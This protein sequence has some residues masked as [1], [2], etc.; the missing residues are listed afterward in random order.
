MNK[1]KQLLENVI[2]YL[3]GQEWS[4]QK[5]KRKTFDQIFQID[6]VPLT[7]FYKRLLLTY[8]LPHKFEIIKLLR[9]A[10]KKEKITFWEGKKYLGWSYLYRYLL[11]INEKMKILAAKKVKPD[12]KEKILFLIP[13]NHFDQ[14]KKFY[15]RVNPIMEK[16]KKEGKEVLPLLFA[17]LSFKSYLQIRKCQKTIYSY[18]DQNLK[19]KAKKRARKLAFFWKKLPENNKEKIFSSSGCS[20]WPYLKQVLNFYFSPKFLFYQCLYYE[21]MLKVLKEENVKTIVLTSQNSI[22]EKSILAAAKIKNIPSVLIQHGLAEGSINPDLLGHTTIA[23]FSPMYKERF[24]KMGIPE[25]QIKTVGPLIFDEITNY[26]QNENDKDKEKNILLI[27]EPFVENNC[28]SKKKY[29]TYITKILTEIK[30][31]K[32][33]SV[34]IKLHPSE[35]FLRD[36]QKLVKKLNNNNNKSY[37]NQLMVTQKVGAKVLYLL[38]NKSSVVFEF[39]S[40]VALE[41]MILGKPVITTNFC[42]ESG[43][44]DLILESKATYQIEAQENVAPLIERILINDYLKEKREEAINYICGPVDGKAA[45]RVVKIIDKLS[46]EN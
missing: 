39:G 20:G 35:L 32:D 21:T 26:K 38:I 31:L 14:K 37:N 36:Y 25:P 12:A 19:R 11:D 16:L 42:P 41:A 29:F 44:Y 6:S 24:R 22:F 43:N 27:T 13:T 40:T 30:E 10:Q 9:K 28:L 23:I 33:V 17:P 46:N 18:I 5:I 45:E 2:D 34:T 1:K 4:K 3:L 8:T 7:W 15:F